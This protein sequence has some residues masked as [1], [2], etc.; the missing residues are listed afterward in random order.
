MIRI[1]EH[2]L[3]ICIVLFHLVLLAIERRGTPA[4]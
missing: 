4:E 1:I 2:T 3:A